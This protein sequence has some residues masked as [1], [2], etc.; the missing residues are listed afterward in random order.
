MFAPCLPPSFVS[1]SWC[2]SI[3]IYSLP[4]FIQSFAFTSVGT[5]IN[6]FTFPL[7]I[8]RFT[9]P[10][11]VN[12]LPVPVPLVNKIALPYNSLGL[13]CWPIKRCSALNT[14]MCWP[15]N[16][17]GNVARMLSISI[18]ITGIGSAACCWIILSSILVPAISVRDPST[19][20]LPS[21]SSCTPIS[22]S[23]LLP[24]PSVSPAGLVSS[25]ASR[26][27]IGIVVSL[28]SPSTTASN[29]SKP[30]LP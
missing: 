28:D 2:V 6:P 17:N 3:P 23:P 10:H 12:V 13:S 26:S 29:G 25:P 21:V 22:S 27:S 18:S 8:M 4:S 30:G 11:P 14:S 5:R 24:V 15:G 1:T 19:V 20:S 16:R 7:F 9:I